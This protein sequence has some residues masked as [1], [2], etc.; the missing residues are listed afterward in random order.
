MRRVGRH[1][2]AAIAVTGIRE[3]RAAGLYDGE[4]EA[5]EAGQARATTPSRSPTGTG[6][7][8]SCRSGRSATCRPRC[9]ATSPTPA[10]GPRWRQPR[11]HR[12][13][14]ARVH[15]QHRVRRPAA[16][17]R[18]AGAARRHPASSGSPP[19]SACGRRRC[20]PTRCKSPHRGS[21]ACVSNR[22]MA[23]TRR[24]R[25]RRRRRHLR[26]AGRLRPRGPRRQDA[27]HLR[28]LR[29]PARRAGR[30]AASTWCS[31]RPRSRST[32]PSTRRC[33]R[34]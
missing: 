26:G 11:P 28:G 3:A 23:R 2:A 27:H 4:L 32:S 15:R 13:D 30:A 19:T 21:R 29:R 34:R 17:I 7:A 20:C 8:T 14:P 1:V 12:A 16:A 9:R 25:L 33:S 18:H 5:V 22:P 31:T 6:C 24:P 10:R